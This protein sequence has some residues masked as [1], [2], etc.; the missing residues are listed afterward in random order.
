[1]NKNNKKTKE[2]NAEIYKNNKQYF[3]DYYQKNKE[4]RKR[5]QLEKY[6]KNPEAERKRARDTNRLVRIQLLDQL[7]G[8]CIRCGFSDERALQFD[9]IDSDFKIDLKR[10]RSVYTMR[11]F[12]VENP[13]ITK[14]KLQLLCANCNWIKRDEKSEVRRKK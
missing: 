3:I 7:G 5:N 1:M 2:E 9:H 11:R 6:H 14:L 8:K 13:I 4:E 12:Y 10:F